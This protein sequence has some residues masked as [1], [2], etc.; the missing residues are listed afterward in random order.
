MDRQPIVYLVD[1]DVRVR[2][3]VRD[4]AQVLDLACATLGS[5]QEFLSAYD[6]S[7]QGCVLL[8]V[9]TPG[10]S[11]LQVQ[12]YLSSLGAT[13][14][15]VFLAA[16]ATVSIAVQAMRNGAIHF[17]EK[18]VRDRELWDTIQEAIRL[19]EKR[20]RLRARR[21]LLD[22]RVGRLTERQH[23][24]M[25]MIAEGKTNR[26]VAGEL[27][28]CVRTIENRRA[29]LMGALKAR[30]LTELLCYALYV[31][32]CRA[33]RKNGHGAMNNDCPICDEHLGQD[34]EGMIGLPFFTAQG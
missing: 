10:M 17:L 24:L 29:Q 28:V 27:G 23:E 12:H 19:D 32:H 30:S 31:R 16:R 3:A 1:D 13:T 18:P 6:A 4:L 20:K 5:G 9:R 25:G 22:A 33:Q 21:Q 15:V 26:Q 14:P 2:D 11:G 34:L 7:R 8:E